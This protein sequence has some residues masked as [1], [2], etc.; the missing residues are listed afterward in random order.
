MSMPYID[1]DLAINENQTDLLDNF[2]IVGNNLSLDISEGDIRIADGNPVKI[3][4]HDALKQ[5]I[6][7]A[8]LTRAYI[9]DIYDI[10]EVQAEESDEPE[11][12]QVYG[13]TVKDIMLDPDMDF[14]EKTAEIQQD[15]E[16]VLSL[17]PDIITVTD[18]TFTRNGRDLTVGFTVTSIYGDDYE[19]VLINGA[20]SE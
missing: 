17:H 19:E 4:G 5:W 3:S 8:F 11:P 12:V 14:E 10:A 16:N 1:D 20:N 13:S 6:A 2:E 18:F 7:K 15:I 9:Y